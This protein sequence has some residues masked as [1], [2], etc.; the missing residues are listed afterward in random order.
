M[1]LT[2]RTFFERGFWE[3]VRREQ[4]TSFGGVPYTYEILEK[5]RFTQME[6]PHLKTMTQA[7]GKLPLHLHQEFAEYA[8]R[9]K[10]RF[11]VMYGQTEA[12]ARMGY[13][14]AHDALER[15]GSMGIAIPG[16]RFWL[17]RDDGSEIEESGVTGELVYEGKNVMLG[18]A[19]NR[20][21][22]SKGDECG[23]LLYTGDMA[24]RDGDGYYYIEGR[25][26]RFL[27]LLL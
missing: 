11:I 26:K 16:G 12:T 13:L 17:Q 5:L 21:D 10:K 20:E 9:N 22:L 14:P 3:F 18:Y 24:R 7:G 4:A 15:C 23:G 2:E 27:K 25:K 19:Q 1:L 8:D 6:L